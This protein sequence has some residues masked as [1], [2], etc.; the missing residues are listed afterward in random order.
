MAGLVALDGGDG[1]GTELAVGGEPLALG[2]E[3]LLHQPDAAAH[4]AAPQHDA[5]VGDDEAVLGRVAGV[6][7]VP[8][9]RAHF[10]VLFEAVPELELPDSLF[11]VCAELSV[12]G[13]GGVPGAAVPDAV[14]PGL[15]EG[16]VRAGAAAL[17]ERVVSRNC[18]SVVTLLP[19]SSYAA[20]RWPVHPASTTSSR[21]AVRPPHHSTNRNRTIYSPQTRSFSA[22]V[23]Y[24]P[25]ADRQRP[26]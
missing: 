17:D 18:H 1:A 22:G 20:C 4:A 8:G 3:L 21:G 7:H 13:K 25:Q 16:H 11:G 12:H 23:S 14:E 19:R 26:G 9:V 24:P 2:V 10:A 6:E 15:H 5:G